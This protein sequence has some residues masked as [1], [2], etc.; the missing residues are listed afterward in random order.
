MGSSLRVWVEVAPGITAQLRAPPGYSHVQRIEES[1]D[2]S[3]PSSQRQGSPAVCSEAATMGAASEGTADSKPCRAKVA[4]LH[5]DWQLV[6]GLEGLQLEQE[7]I[8]ITSG[9][10]QCFDLL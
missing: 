2:A 8:S 9:E 7:T 5:A 6:D 1:K 3:A 4:A 10:R